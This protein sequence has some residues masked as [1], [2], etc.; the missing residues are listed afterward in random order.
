MDRDLTRN[1]NAQTKTK[2]TNRNKRS[3]NVMM[4]N[5]SLE[6]QNNPPGNSKR[7]CLE[8][9]DVLGKEGSNE[10][11]E[12]QDDLVTPA[13]IPAVSE[14]LTV[15]PVTAPNN[16]LLNKKE[17]NDEDPNIESSEIETDEASLSINSA[18]GAEAL[19]IQ[20]LQQSKNRSSAN[21]NIGPAEI[22]ATQA[23][24]SEQNLAP[25][26]LLVN[27][28]ANALADSLNRLGPSAI[29]H[30][31][32]RTPPSAKTSKVYLKQ[33]SSEEYRGFDP[34]ERVSDE[35]ILRIFHQL[36]RH[37]MCTCALVCRR[38]ARIVCD[39][40]L[41]RR[42]D[43]GGRPLKVGVLK[44][45]LERGVEVLRLN[46]S[47][48]IFVLISCSILLEHLRCYI[49]LLSRKWDLPFPI[50]LESNARLTQ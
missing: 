41:W 6:D 35:I 7:I 14:S 42:M 43:F 12:N 29:F 1:A 47:E 48:V 17:G 24:L 13:A 2:S 10:L 18:D 11:C 3:S 20:Y 27:Q 19:A 44:I 45:L 38:W 15:P 31:I 16:D 4:E 32:L 39:I 9:D 25:R 33:K 22:H 28:Q 40:S 23:F 30:Q 26:I 21:M 5:L 46:R 36:P 37:T 49:R 34:F 50:Q 8:E